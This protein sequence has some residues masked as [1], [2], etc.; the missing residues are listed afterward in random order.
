[1][2]SHGGG[3]FTYDYCN[4]SQLG[5]HTVEGIISSA[6]VEQGWAYDINITL[7]GKVLGIATTLMH[8]ILIL[9]LISLGFL[10][11][12]MSASADLEKWNKKLYQEYKDRNYVKMVLGTIGYHIAKSKF[13]I[14][15]LIGL[16]IIL[17][18]TEASLL[19]NLEAFHT[20]LQ[21]FLIV[22][23]IGVVIVG[24]VFLSHIQEWFL[25]LLKMIQDNDWG[26]ER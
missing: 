16:P 24:I 17:V 12:H 4:T 15:Y 10:Y 2:T 7:T 23:V 19:Y 20:V 1:M 3:I 8:I 14:Y 13:I 25:D 26:I 21:N 5:I 18:V 9:L 11:H 22:Y 6:G